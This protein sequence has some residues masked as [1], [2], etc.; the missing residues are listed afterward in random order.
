MSLERASGVLLHP[1]SLPSRHGIGDLGKGAY[2]F[3]DFLQASGQ[4]YWQ[5]LPLGPTGYEHSPY[6]MNYSTFAGNPLMISLEKL[7]DQGLLQREE[8]TPLP[9]LSESRRGF[10]GCQVEFDRVIPHKT[11]FLEKAY[12]RFIQRLQHDRHYAFEDFCRS[13]PWLEDYALFMAL[14]EAHPNQ[15][16]NQWPDGLARRDPQALAKARQTLRDRIQYHRFLQFQFFDQWRQIR[17]H[18]NDRGIRIIGDISIYVCYHSADVWS[19]PDLFQLQPDTLEPAYIAGVPPDYF[20]ETGQLWGNPVY[21]WDKMQETGFSWWIDRFRATLHYADLVRI[22]HFRG[23]EAYW[24]VPGGETTAI[25]GEWVTAP[26][27]EFFQKLR[28]TLGYLPVLAEDLGTITPAVEEMRDRYGFPGMKILQFAFGD[29]DG[30]NPYLPYNHPHNA[31][32]YP[33]THDNDTAI[34]WWTSLG[35]AEKQRV[36]YF[37]GYD[38]PEE[39]KE[40]HWELIR[41]ALSSPANLAI[42]PLQDLLGLDSQARMNDPAINEGNWR[43]HYPFSHLLAPE[44]SQRLLKLTQIYRRS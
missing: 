18:A 10:S 5:I 4:K 32:V 13:Q 27:H 26:G 14:V 34:G 38:R 40:I 39:V 25:N 11:I 1:T 21:N 16:W 31:V 36:T 43:W 7:V 9:P 41:V 12:D 23:F 35:T 2:D 28:D 17:Q 20:S 44:I 8:L 24:R 3:V 37:L 29:N 33:G 22:D 19:S 6:I 15:A 30:T 42:L